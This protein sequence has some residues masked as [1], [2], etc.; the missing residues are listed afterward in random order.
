MLNDLV[1]G[2]PFPTCSM[3]GAGNKASHQWSNAPSYCPPQYTHSYELESVTVY[4]C[5]YDGAVEVDVGGVLWT[6]TWWRSGGDS[7]TEYTPAAKAQLGTWDTRFD[8]DYARWLASQPA[9]VTT[10]PSTGA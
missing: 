5:D 10:A 4:G 7:V 9:P 8:D 3:S 6:R 1:H 2:R